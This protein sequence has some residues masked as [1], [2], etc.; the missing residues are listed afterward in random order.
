LAARRVERSHL[1]GEVRRHL[2]GLLRQQQVEA[3]GIEDDAIALLTD[4]ALP[5]V[6]DAVA[7][8]LGHRDA[9][10]VLLGA[11]AD[12]APRVAA[13]V[14][15]F[16]FALA[17]SHGGRSSDSMS[18]IRYGRFGSST[19]PSSRRSS[20]SITSGFIFRSTASV[21]GRKLHRNR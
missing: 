6:V 8:D 13:Q 14:E 18:G 4:H 10:R 11:I 3:L 2:H 15:L 7:A 16:G 17:R 20:S 1:G 19:A 5:V 21:S 9:R 12:L